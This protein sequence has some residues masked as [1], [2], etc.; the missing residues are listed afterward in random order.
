ME[1]KKKLKR[2]AILSVFI[3]IMINGFIWGFMKAYINCSNCNTLVTIEKGEFEY[4]IFSAK[5]ETKDSLTVTYKLMNV[6]PV[7]GKPLNSDKQTV[8]FTSE[9]IVANN[10]I[11]L[12]LCEIIRKDY[13]TA[14]SELTVVKKSDNLSVTYDETTHKYMHNLK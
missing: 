7:C 3:Y 8:C 13:T 2:A 4:V 12:K 11:I 5:K 1:R 10:P 14:V 6:C 9:E